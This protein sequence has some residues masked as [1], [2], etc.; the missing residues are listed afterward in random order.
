MNYSVIQH[1][2][3]LDSSEHPELNRQEFGKLV[4]ET[5]LKFT[6]TLTKMN[7][8]FVAQQDLTAIGVQT[9]FWNINGYAAIRQIT[10]Y[11]IEKDGILVRFDATTLAKATESVKANGSLKAVPLPSTVSIEPSKDVVLP[12][13]VIDGEEIDVTNGAPM[14]YPEEKMN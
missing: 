1:N 11:Q 5:L 9:R 3:T 13:V 6:A 10:M 8:E 14:K 4:D 7:A 2:V 12:M